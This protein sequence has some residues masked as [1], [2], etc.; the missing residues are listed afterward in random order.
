[1]PQAFQR[2]PNALATL[3]RMQPKS[4]ASYGEEAEL[5]D[6][7]PE[8]DLYAAQDEI[9]ERGRTSGRPYA[10]PSREALK[11]SGVSSLK[12]LFGE[13]GAK[14]RA[15]AY[16]RQIQGEYDLRGIERKGQ[17]DVEAAKQ[18]EQAEAAQR[19]TQ[20]Q[21]QV[22]QQRRGQ[23]FGAEQGRVGREAIAG[24]QTTSQAATATRSRET[25]AAIDRRQ[26]ARKPWNLKD[27]FSSLWGKPKPEN[28]EAATAVA[29]ARQEYPGTSL[30]NLI[31]NGV[32]A[33]DTPEELAALQAAWGQ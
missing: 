16:P 29:S 23:E 26:E 20:R 17:Y 2:D 4:Y 9:G 13:I 32:L 11:S 3:L 8:E 1:M 22:D 27:F 33:Y 14:G 5:G 6:M 31:Q 7:I 24:R 19:E 21:F 28:N 30:E 25:Q 10:I 15:A 18:K 12:R